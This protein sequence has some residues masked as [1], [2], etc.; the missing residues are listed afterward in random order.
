MKVIEYNSIGTPAEVLEIK[1]VPS[2]APGEAEVR[3]QVLATPIHPS[4]LL[5]IMG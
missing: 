3:V 4:S 5:Q 2:R 1:D